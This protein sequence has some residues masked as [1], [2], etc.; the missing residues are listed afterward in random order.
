MHIIM[1]Q[2]VNACK[3]KTNESNKRKFR[4]QKYIHV[5]E[6]VKDIEKSSSLFSLY[7]SL[8]TGIIL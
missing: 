1:E 5:C 4:R 6:F 2:G 7:F 8:K 3:R